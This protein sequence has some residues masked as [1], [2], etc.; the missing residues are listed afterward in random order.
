MDVWSA[1]A[2]TVRIVVS[3]V[4]PGH[5]FRTTAASNYPPGGASANMPCIGVMISDV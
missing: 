3:I 1:V 4:A 5:R 2:G